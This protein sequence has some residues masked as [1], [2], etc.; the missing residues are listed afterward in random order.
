MNRRFLVFAGETYYASGM[1]DFQLATDSWMEAVSEAKD[2]GVDWGII[3]DVMLGTY[4]Q[5]G[6]IHGDPKD[7]PKEFE[8]YPLVKRKDWE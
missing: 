7:Y 4:H 5:F 1:K 3:I 2:A 8:S 6:N